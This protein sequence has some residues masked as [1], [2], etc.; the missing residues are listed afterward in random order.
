MLFHILILSFLVN[1]ADTELNK[2]RN[3]L[4]GG[5]TNASDV[6]DATK[7]NIN[8]TVSDA[9]DLAEDAKTAFEQGKYVAAG[10]LTA[11]AK[12]AESALDQQ[13]KEVENVS[14]LIIVD[15]SFVRCN[16]YIHDFR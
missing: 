13:L 3:S 10:A 9:T 7:Q 12:A 2:A 14:E 4:I 8:K 11:G 6:I 1:E 16:V 5:I 15:Y